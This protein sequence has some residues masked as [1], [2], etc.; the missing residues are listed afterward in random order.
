MSGGYSFPQHLFVETMMQWTEF[1]AL[2]AAILVLITAALCMW[3]DD[4]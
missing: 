3:S 1:Y 4:R 2:G